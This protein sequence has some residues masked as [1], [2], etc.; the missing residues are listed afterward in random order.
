MP[1][2]EDILSAEKT[3]QNFL[4]PDRCLYDHPL[5]AWQL[6]LLTLLSYSYVQLLTLKLSLRPSS[7]DFYV[8]LPDLPATLFWFFF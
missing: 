1:K 6:L 3:S 7:H 4:F 8:S 2:M 5:R